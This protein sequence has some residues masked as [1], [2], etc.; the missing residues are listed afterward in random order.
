MNIEKNKF[1]VTFGPSFIT[2]VRAVMIDYDK[3]IF[4]G[5]FSISSDELKKINKLLPNLN[6]EK[7]SFSEIENVHKLLPMLVNALQDI[8]NSVETNAGVIEL[9]EGKFILYPVRPSWTN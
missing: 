2:P 6:Y 3:S 4:D 8:G 7:F 5:N 1:K 9:D